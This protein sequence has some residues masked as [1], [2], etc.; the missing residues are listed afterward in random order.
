MSIHDGYGA[1]GAISGTGSAIG[2]LG[3]AAIMA[4]ALSRQD[5]DR[6]AANAAACQAAAERARS[7]VLLSATETLR[8]RLADAAADLE[9]AE[10]EIGILRRQV[11]E[12]TQHRQILADALRAERA[13]IAA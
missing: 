6:R 7:G 2:G 10:G 3:Q 5:G 9:V 12:L 1:H 4:F 13:A 8:E 11:A